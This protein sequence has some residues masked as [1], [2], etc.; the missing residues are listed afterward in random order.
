M[1]EAIHG[2]LQIIDNKKNFTG[3]NTLAFVKAQK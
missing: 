3:V 1:S 2:S